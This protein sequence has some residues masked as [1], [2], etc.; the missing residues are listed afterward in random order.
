MQQGD[1]DLGQARSDATPIEQRL[2]QLE[3]K[4]SQLLDRLPTRSTV[5]SG[6]HSSQKS[7]GQTLD[8][9]RDQIL[10]LSDVGSLRWRL[11]PTSSPEGATETARPHAFKD[12]PLLSILADSD[13]SSRRDGHLRAPTSAQEADVGSLSMSPLESRILPSLKNL[14]PSLNDVT[15][16]MHSTPALQ[17]VWYHLFPALKPNPPS[18]PINPISDRAQLQVI[19]THYRSTMEMG[20]LPATTKAMILVTMHLQQLPPNFDIKQ[21]SLSSAP[22]ML[23]EQYMILIEMILTADDGIAGTV[24]GL[25]CMILQFEYYNNLGN[26]RQAWLISRRMVSTAYLLGLHRE[27]NDPH[28]RSLWLQIVHRDRALAL[29]LGLPYAIHETHIDHAASASGSKDV[30]NDEEFL[31]ALD[32]VTGHVID[33]NQS[34]NALDFLRT[35]QCNEELEECKGLKSEDQ[36]T[37]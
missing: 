2:G 31:C 30:T 37:T 22:Q 34:Q 32:I 25:K 18:G 23:Q 11:S 14:A 5:F 28:L 21:T 13:Y 33:R 12:A 3:G 26:P 9:L 29:V 8:T 19:T 24:D 27:K 16:I 20:G 1:T 15:L 17:S 35:M 10:S 4:L 7:T 6:S 36:W